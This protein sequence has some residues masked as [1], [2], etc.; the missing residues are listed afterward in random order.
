MVG[1]LKASMRGQTKTSTTEFHVVKFSL[2]PAVWR[3]AR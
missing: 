1:A 2:S 3:S